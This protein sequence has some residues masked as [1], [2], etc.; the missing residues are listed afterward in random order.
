MT[1]R[2]NQN[3]SVPE[4]IQKDTISTSV[5]IIPISS[6]ASPDT[7]GFQDPLEN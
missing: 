1:V 7:A 2:F 3:L 4:N 5:D 6:G